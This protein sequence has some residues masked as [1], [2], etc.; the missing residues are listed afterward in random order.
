[1]FLAP[2]LHFS[3]CTSERDLARQILYRSKVSSPILGPISQYKMIRPT[4]YHPSIFRHIFS[5]YKW[6]IY[7]NFAM[8][9]EHLGLLYL[10]ALRTR[11][12]IDK[13]CY[14]TSVMLDLSKANHAP[15]LVFKWRRRKCFW[16]EIPVLIN[17]INFIRTLFL[18]KKQGRRLNWCQQ[19]HSHISLLPQTLGSNTLILNAAVTLQLPRTWTGRYGGSKGAGD[20]PRN[21]QGSTFLQRKGCM[22]RMISDQERQDQSEQT[23]MRKCSR[24]KS[25][26]NLPTNSIQAEKTPIW[27]SNQKNLRNTVA[28]WLQVL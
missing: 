13:R 27:T 8:I 9:N 20:I 17:V 7:I 21:L 22:Y 10:L 24:N 2:R 15:S 6:L 12:L 5:T 1:M 23:N 16:R 28:E 14:W 18:V 11:T 25:K 26:R 4:K 3:G 19:L